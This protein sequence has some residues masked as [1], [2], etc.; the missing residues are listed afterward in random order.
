MEPATTGK[1]A[2]TK[3]MNYHWMIKP[4][5]YRSCYEMLLPVLLLATVRDEL[6]FGI[7]SKTYIYLSSAAA[8][9][10]VDHP[11]DQD[12]SDD[13]RADRSDEVTGFP[14]QAGQ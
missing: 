3:V 9:D 5:E 8:T 7:P 13:A 2:A 12:E 11:D 14:T 6:V 1:N 4:S 10:S